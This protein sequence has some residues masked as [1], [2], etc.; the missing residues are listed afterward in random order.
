MTP[1]DLAATIYRHFGV[2]LDSTY[3]DP[4]GRVAQP[5]ARRRR[6]GAG[7]VLGSPAGP[8]FTSVSRPSPWRPRHPA[9][10]TPSTS[11]EFPRAC[12]RASR[13][14]CEAHRSSAGPCGRGRSRRPGCQIGWAPRRI[15][16]SLIGRAGE[17]FGVAGRVLAD[18]ASPPSRTTL[19]CCASIPRSSGASPSSNRQA[20]SARRPSSTLTSSITWPKSRSLSRG[21][22]NATPLEGLIE[23]VERDL[24]AVEVE[25]HVP[26]LV[27]LAHDRPC[28]PPACPGPRRCGSAQSFDGVGR[29]AVNRQAQ[30]G[31]P[32]AQNRAPEHNRTASPRDR[33]SLARH[34]E[35]L[36]FDG[37]RWRESPSPPESYREAECRQKLL[38]VESYNWNV[39]FRQARRS[40][41]RAT[42][43]ATR[44]PL[45]QI[46]QQHLG[47]FVAPDR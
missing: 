32:A 24:L 38:I 43:L 20:A 39:L 29:H 5:P 7:T 12:P 34:R 25:Q 46:E 9:R 4:A 47:R 27:V 33:E 22:E 42:R 37:I 3:A 10:G 1:G 11:S 21:I 8:R 44:D 23:L 18:R 17:L 40:R 2:P 36:R 15:A 28:L 13:R 31:R 30:P 41:A 16:P 6:A 14:S 26:L 35:F 19:P 45:R